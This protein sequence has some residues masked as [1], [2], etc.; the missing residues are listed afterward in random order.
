MTLTDEAVIAAMQQ[1]GSQRKAATHL[2]VH[3]RTLERYLQ[4]LTLRGHSPAHDMTKLVP[5]GFNVKG[6]SSYYDKDGNLRGQW[7]KSQ[8]DR[9]QVQ[10]MLE[11]AFAGFK[12]EIPRIKRT[13]AP[14]LTVADLCNTYVISDY[15]LGML[16]YQEDSGADWNLQLA[17]DALAAWFAEAIKQAPDAE[18]GILAQLGDFLHWD[19]MEAVTPTS[20]HVLDAD[21]KF[22]SLVRASIRVLRQIITM[23]LAKHKKVH[24]LMAEGNHD[25]ASSAMM[26]EWMAA[27]YEN[28]PR[29][30][31]DTSADPYY[32]YEHGKT[33]LFFHHG[34]KRR[35]GDIDAVF[36][37]KFREVFGRTKHSF[38]HMGHLHHI[39]VKETNLMVVEQHRTLAA[40]DAYAARGGWMSGRDAKVITYSKR[41]GEAGRVTVP[42][43]RIYH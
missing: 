26:R 5:D 8:Q 17:E 39:D 27:L 6:V 15:H 18:V 37:A 12:D 16:S 14:Q 32:C 25:L 35:I 33:S 31:V 30:T 43:E 28:E 10:K 34:H 24:V 1:C 13:A 41:Y 38:A 19:G 42:F 11:A 29:V 9:D 21:G 22:Q 3:R 7:V 40:P 4:K 36:A 20:H 23:L 2:G